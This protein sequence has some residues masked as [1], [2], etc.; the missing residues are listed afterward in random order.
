MALKTF[1][2]EFL[3]SHGAHVEVPTKMRKHRET[4]VFNGQREVL[5]EI[6]PMHIAQRQEWTETVD[7]EERKESWFMRYNGQ[8]YDCTRC[9]IWHSDG[10]CP[11]WVSRLEE[12]KNEGQQKS[13]FF[14]SSNFLRHMQFF[15]KV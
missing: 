14:S 10:N 15:K 3:T 2:D 11:K 4:N 8:P 6:G 7:G 1:F 13:F 5:V 12:K 9:Q